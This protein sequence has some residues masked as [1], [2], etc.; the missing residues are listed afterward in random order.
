MG[1]AVALIV[2]A[3]LGRR[4][5]LDDRG[6]LSAGVAAAFVLPVAIFGLGHWDEARFE[7]SP[8]T[9]GLVEQLEALPDGAVVLSDDS[10]GYWVASA[11]PV[12]IVA[13]R[14]GH[15]AD[16]KQNRPYE[17]RDDV[18]RFG[19]T[20]DLSIARRYRADYVLV[21]RDRWPRLDLPLRVVYR[22]SRYVL[23]RL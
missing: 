17:R 4:G 13:A 1:G 14:P 10:T 23:Y 18:N 20:G 22:D 8:L 21:R 3:V 2:A 9:Q 7:P 11:A 6:P 16:T 5:A 12:Y 19:R 15:V